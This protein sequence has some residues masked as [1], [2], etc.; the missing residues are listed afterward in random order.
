MRSGLNEVQQG[1]LR[2]DIEE[3]PESSI[4]TPS[5]KNL[6]EMVC[7]TKEQRGRFNQDTVNLMKSLSPNRSWLERSNGVMPSVALGISAGLVA[8]IPVYA[9]IF[10]I[11]QT[12]CPELRG[13]VFSPSIQGGISYSEVILLTSVKMSGS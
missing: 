1:G 8:G 12:A 6:Q 3:I 7:E 5:Y 13:S 2:E 10:L 11:K 4:N 9:G